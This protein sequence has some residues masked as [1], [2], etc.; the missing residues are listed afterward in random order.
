MKKL[1]IAL[2]VLS[3]CAVTRPPYI[4]VAKMDHT[5]GYKYIYQD[6]K[7]GLYWYV[8]TCNYQVGD[9]LKIVK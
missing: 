9:S 7:N 3:S 6:G 5:D 4:I 8:D 1:L 2:I